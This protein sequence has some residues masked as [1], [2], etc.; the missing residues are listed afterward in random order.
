[1]KTN[2][3]REQRMAWQGLVVKAAS[4]VV[5]GVVGVA[6]Y[7]L[8]RKAVAKVPVREAAV[9]ATA[10]GL[11]GVR[12]AEEGAERARLNIADVV[13]EARERIGEEAIPPTTESSGHDHDH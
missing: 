10:V 4:T 2:K 6:G 11:Q 12:K 9:S 3:Q 7:E 8:I 1:M 13:A 5:T